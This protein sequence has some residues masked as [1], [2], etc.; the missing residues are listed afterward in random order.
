ME[1]KRVDKLRKDHLDVVKIRDRLI[2][3]PNN[4]DIRFEMAQWMLEH[5]RSEETKCWIQT[6]LAMQP[7]HVPALR[8][9]AKY[10]EGA[11]EIGLANYYRSVAE[12]VP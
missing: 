2:A 12:T 1:R 10:H 6:I 3:D 5:G 4:N 7:K 8:L 11:G 9:L